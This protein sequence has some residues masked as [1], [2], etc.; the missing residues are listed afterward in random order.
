MAS[1]PPPSGRNVD[2]EVSFNWPGQTP[3]RQDPGVLEARVAQRRQRQQQQQD[4]QQQRSQRAQ[5]QQP[6][7]PESKLPA[8]REDV[9]PSGARDR[10]IVTELRRQAVATEGSLR[11]INERL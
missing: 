10:W 3:R 2:P 11:D 5:Q 4:Q 1:K 9:S 6:A 7:E 8:R